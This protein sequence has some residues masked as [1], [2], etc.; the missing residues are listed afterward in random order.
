MYLFSYVCIGLVLI[1]CLT[2]CVEHVHIHVHVQLTLCFLLI[3]GEVFDYLVAHGRMKE[4]EARVKFRQVRKC[5][6]IGSQSTC[7]EYFHNRLCRL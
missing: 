7:T 2:G 4:R 5:F 6:V 3:I 1:S